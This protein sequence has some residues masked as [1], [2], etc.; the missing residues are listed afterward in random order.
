MLL[1]TDSL[2]SNYDLSVINEAKVLRLSIEKMLQVLVD[3]G[4]SFRT[5]NNNGLYIIE[6]FTSVEDLKVFRLQNI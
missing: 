4:K 6:N 1:G 5:G 2:A 3:N